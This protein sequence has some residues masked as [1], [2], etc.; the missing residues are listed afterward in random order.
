MLSVLGCLLILYLVTTAW[1]T[2]KRKTATIDR[3][4]YA[5]AIFILATTIAYFKYGI[6]AANSAVAL[7]GGFNHVPYFF[8][9]I[10]AAA[11]FLLD[12]RL[13]VA[14]GISGACASACG[15]P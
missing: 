12:V 4:D 11:C 3:L 5:A 1:I 15:L 13:I 10:I 14:G 8:F 7:K 2:V 9:G 6:D